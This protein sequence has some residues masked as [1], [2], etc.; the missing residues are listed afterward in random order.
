MRVF[1]QRAA[2]WWRTL[3]LLDDWRSR[4]SLLR[5]KV[6]EK[7]S[8]GDGRDAEEIPVTVAVPEPHVIWLRPAAADASLIEGYLSSGQHLPEGAIASEELEQI[9][10]FGTNIG[11]GLADLALRYPGARLLGVEPDAANAG[12]AR[13]NLEPFADRCT[14]VEGAVWERDE[15]LELVESEHEGLISASR[16]GSGGRAVSGIRAETLLERHMPEGPIDYLHLDMVGTEPRILGPGT[17][18]VRRVR[19]L[20]IQLYSDRGFSAGECLDLLRELGFEPSLHHG[21]HGDY[22][23]AVR[24]AGASLPDGSTEDGR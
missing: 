18:W 9:C 6:A 7:L 10:E 17:A 20:K 1:A 5:G 22:A 13:R 21:H 2:V 19:S 8:R 15:E 16:A 23:F 3:R 24:G 11:I 4:L 12:L 14:I